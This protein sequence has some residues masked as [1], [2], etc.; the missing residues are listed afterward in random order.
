MPASA[1]TTWQN[2]PDVPITGG[3]T[4]TSYTLDSTSGRLYVPVG[5]PAPDFVPEARAGANL[6]SNTVLALDAKTGA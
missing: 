4:W 1:I 2:A 3:A 5:N 6:Y